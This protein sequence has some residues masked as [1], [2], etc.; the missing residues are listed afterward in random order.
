[1]T[2]QKHDIANIQFEAGSVANNFVAGTR[3]NTQSIYD[4]TGNNT[5]TANNLNCLSDGT[6]TFNGSS[7]Y[8]S[9]PN[10]AVFNMTTGLTIESWVKFDGNSDDFIFENC[11]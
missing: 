10:N 8:L 5:V 3:T 6:Y 7:S 4:L 9:I 11:T 1:M 2:L